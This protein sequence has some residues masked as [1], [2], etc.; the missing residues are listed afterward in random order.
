MKSK[1]VSPISYLPFL[2]IFLVIALIVL[3]FVLFSQTKPNV[4][5]TTDTVAT[6][7]YGKEFY[8][9]LGTGAVI[10]TDW[11]DVKGAAAYIDTKLY[12]K[13][14]KVTF[15]ASISVPSGT[16]SV[17]LFNATDKHPVW[18]SEMTLSNAG[19]ELLTSSGITLDGG[20]KLYQVQMKSQL[21]ATTNLLQSRV[22]TII[23]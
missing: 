21:G 12:G 17:R 20:N 18:Y 8:I 5:G 6:I 2:A 13:F 22:H 10:S 19:P 11:T 9:P 23:N 4:L 3:V 1:K 14:K 15:E 7:S 16:A